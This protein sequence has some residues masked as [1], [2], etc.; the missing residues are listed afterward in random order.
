MYLYK[1]VSPSGGVYIGQTNDF[2]GRMSKHKYRSD[3]SNLPLYN[4]IR[5]Y[6]WENFEQKILVELP[7]DKIDWEEIKL[8][9]FS[10]LFFKCYNVSPGGNKNKTLSPETKAKISFANSGSKNYNAKAVNQHDLSGQFLN[11]YETIRE[12]QQQTG[13]LIPQVFQKSVKANL[14]QQVVSF[15]NTFEKL[16]SLMRAG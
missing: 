13:T 7:E 6:G 3:I 4:A 2:K 15:G 11:Q 1:L 8:I 9:S 16:K 5:K 14:N 12:A 10:C